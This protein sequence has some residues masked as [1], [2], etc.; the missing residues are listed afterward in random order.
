MAGGKPTAVTSGTGI[1]WSPVET[2]D[3]KAVAM[4][5]S[6]AKVPPRPALVAGTARA[7]R[8]RARS[9]PRGFPASALVA[10]QQVIFP[11]GDGM[12][13][14][15]QL[16]LPPGGAKGERHP[17]VVFFHGGSRRQMLLGWHYMYYYSNAYAMN[18]YLASRGY[19]VLSVNYRSGI[20]YGLDFREALDYGATGGSEYNDVQGAGLFLRG[21]RGRGFV[22][23]RRVGRIV[24]RLS[25]R[26]GAG[27]L[28]GHLRGRR[29]H[30][31]RARLESGVGDVRS[32]LAHP[33]GSGGARARHSSRRPWRTN[34][35][36]ARRCCS[37]RATTIATSR[38]ARP[39]SSPKIC[40]SRAWMSSS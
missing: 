11:S 23:H 40:A 4:L 31:R 18:Q 12:L 13:L 3:G 34:R 28:V 5:R 25:D 24:R 1:E 38:S 14:H 27:A 19:V 37:F 33:Q 35:R 17:A 20:G 21:A 8:H 39:C 6:D 36:G 2:S 30:P 29:R 9:H 10:P 15:G 26:A 7:A 32:G 22:A 16:F